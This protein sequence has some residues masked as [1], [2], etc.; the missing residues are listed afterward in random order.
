MNFCRS[1]LFHMKTRVCRGSSGLAKLVMTNVSFDNQQH[2]TKVKR[3]ICVNQ[4]G[5]VSS[6]TT[7]T[8][9]SIHSICKT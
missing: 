4:I 7:E 8:N 3:F 2:E 1:A 5:L 6:V 9:V